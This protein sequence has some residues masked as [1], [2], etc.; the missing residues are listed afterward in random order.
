MSYS[1]SIEGM[2]CQACTEKITNALR[3]LEG[4]VGAEVTL[5]PPRAEVKVSHHI[6]SDVFKQAVADVGDYSL[7][8]LDTSEA[9]LGPSSAESE[10]ANDESLYPL[11]LIVGYIL[12]TVLVIHFL[13]VGVTWQDSMRHFMAGFFITFSFFKLLDLNGFVSAFRGYDILARRSEVWARA[14]PFVELALG[15]AYLINVFPV[16][17]NS[18][19]LFIMLVGALGVAK[20]LLDKRS[21]RCAC[22]GTALNLPMT[23]VTLVEDSVMALMAFAM[24]LLYIV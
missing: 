16:V 10:D 17:V 3:K 11:F 1:F 2:H 13:A 7:K 20:A 6:P 18:V 9:N 12:G 24:L 4:V 23:T 14:Y 21:I 19:T 15:F 5:E 8:E 22:L